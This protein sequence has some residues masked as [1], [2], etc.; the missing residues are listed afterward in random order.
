MPINN[1]LYNGV[2]YVGFKDAGAASSFLR[3]ITE[4]NADNSVISVFMCPAQLAIEGY[5]GDLDSWVNGTDIE[6]PAPYEKD[7]EIYFDPTEYFQGFVPNNMKL[8]TYPYIG[9]AVDTLSC[10]TVYRWEWFIFNTFTKATFGLLG[11]ISPNSEIRVSPKYY[12]TA[13]NKYNYTESNFVTG[14]PQCAWAI[15]SYAAWLAQKSTAEY[16]NMAQTATNGFAGVVGSLMQGNIGGAVSSGVNAVFDLAGQHNQQVLEQTRGDTPRGNIGGNV[17]TGARIKGVYY[18][19]I[20]ITNE[21]AKQIDAFFDRFGYAVKQIKKPVR[22]NRKHYTYVRTSGCQ[23]RCISGRSI[24][25]DAANKIKSIYDN[26]V[27]FW[28]Y[29]LGDQNFIIGNYYLAGDND[30]LYGKGFN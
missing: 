9:I 14:F 4:D 26:G 10:A 24:P 6:N 2:R 19:K 18:K 5:S 27:T 3:G 30:P 15:D 22:K 12:Q 25:A 13:E 7:T 11:A 23:I 21:Y 29:N 16:L 8:Y 17:D 1:G 28:N 20:T